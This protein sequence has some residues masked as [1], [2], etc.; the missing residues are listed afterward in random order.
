MHQA[1]RQL[2]IAAQSRHFR[3]LRQMRLEQELMTPGEAGKGDQRFSGGFLIVEQPVPGIDIKSRLQ[4]QPQ[5]EVAV[6]RGLGKDCQLRRQGQHIGFQLSRGSSTAAA[7]DALQPGRMST[8]PLFRGLRQA[9]RGRA[10]GASK[11]DANRLLH[12]VQV[13]NS[14]GVVEPGQ[15]GDGAVPPLAHHLFH[16]SPPF[17]V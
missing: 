9:Q 3:A 14:L 5:V 12:L 13:H 16:Q 15:P 8:Y 1:F 7:R 6:Q 2:R 17:N 4:G 11:Q 10:A